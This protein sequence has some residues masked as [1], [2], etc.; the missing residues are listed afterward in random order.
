MAARQCGFDDVRIIKKTIGISLR[1][2]NEFQINNYTVGCEN[3][4]LT[5]IVSIKAL[6]TLKYYNGMFRNLIF[7]WTK[8]IIINYPTI[9]ALVNI[10]TIL[11]SLKNII[12]A[13]LLLLFY[14]LNLAFSIS[15]SSLKLVCHHSILKQRHRNNKIRF[16]TNH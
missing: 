7:G 8:E 2:A 14:L 13:V 1:Y 12:V 4:R 5:T 16:T 10:M 9:V 6:C 15:P 3:K 11:M